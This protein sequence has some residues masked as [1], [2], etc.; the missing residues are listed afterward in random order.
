MKV[1][2]DEIRK[3]IIQCSEC[4]KRLH[5][6]LDFIGKENQNSTLELKGKWMQPRERRYWERNHHRQIS[7]FDIWASGH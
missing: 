4:R 6:R 5:Y 7:I 1:D 3:H 2:C